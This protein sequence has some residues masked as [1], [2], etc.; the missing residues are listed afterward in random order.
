[1]PIYEIS[2][3]IVFASFSKNSLTMG[4]YTIAFFYNR[5]PF[6][7]EN[8]NVKAVISFSPGGYFRDKLPSLKAVNP[9]IKQ[10]FLLHPLRR[11]KRMLKKNKPSKKQ[12]QF[13]PESD[14]F[15]GSRALWVGQNGADKYWL[16]LKDFL[17]VI[18]KQ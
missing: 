12:L 3:A 16:A 7:K 18:N 14:G 11:I 8:A 13:I 9:K 1:M 2:E 10:F 17:N 15:H 5:R 4:H 6:C